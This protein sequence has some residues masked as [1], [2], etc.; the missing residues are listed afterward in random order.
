M[1]RKFFDTVSPKKSRQEETQ[2]DENNNAEIKTIVGVIRTFLNNLIRDD[3]DDDD[4]DDDIMVRMTMVL[5]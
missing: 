1:E 3:D 5:K 2:H 4:D